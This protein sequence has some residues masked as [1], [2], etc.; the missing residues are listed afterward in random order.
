MSNITITR[1]ENYG[2]N[3]AIRGFEGRV[4]DG[5]LKM[6]ALQSRCLGGVFLLSNLN[7]ELAKCII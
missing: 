3:T 5:G 6:R 4:Q 2:R 1:F 7:A